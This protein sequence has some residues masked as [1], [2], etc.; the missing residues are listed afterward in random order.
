MREKRRALL[1]FTWKFGKIAR[2]DSRNIT[3]PLCDERYSPC[4]TLLTLESAI[5]IEY[6]RVKSLRI[7][8]PILTEESARQCWEHLVF[9]LTIVR[10]VATSVERCRDNEGNKR[11]GGR[12]GR[13]KKPRRPDPV[14]AHGPGCPGIRVNY[15]PIGAPRRAPRDQIARHI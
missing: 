12:I 6:R 5:G 9:L 15:S 14:R 11:D 7:A 3:S 2:K 4:H 13:S 10:I 1:E 8:L